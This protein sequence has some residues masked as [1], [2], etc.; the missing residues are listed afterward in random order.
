MITVVEAPE[1]REGMVLGVV[2]RM[3]GAEAGDTVKIPV[4]RSPV[5]VTKNS[6]DTVSLTATLRVTVAGF[7]WSKATFSL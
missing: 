2:R 3:Y 6:M 7:T 5:F 4:S 1:R